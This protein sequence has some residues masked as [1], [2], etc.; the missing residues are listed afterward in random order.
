[1][2]G[3]TL[4]ELGLFWEKTLGKILLLFSVTQRDFIEK[5]KTPGGVY[6]R[7]EETRYKPEKEQLHLNMRGEGQ[8]PKW[9]ESAAAAKEEVECSP[10]TDMFRTLLDIQQYSLVLG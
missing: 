7:A 9:W 8:I 5:M 4:E 2:Y 1:M 10:S 6:K 3:H